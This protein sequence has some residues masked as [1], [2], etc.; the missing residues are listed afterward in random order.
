MFIL[1]D[2][3]EFLWFTDDFRVGKQAQRG[4]RACSSYTAILWIELGLDSQLLSLRQILL[5]QP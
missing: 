5:P 4:L 3:L 2:N 1:R